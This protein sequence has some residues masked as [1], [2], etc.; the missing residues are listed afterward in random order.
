M[1]NIK[2]A[3]SIAVATLCSLS[4]LAGCIFAPSSSDSEK[5]SQSS[6]SP[7]KPVTSVLP[8]Y[9]A[10][11]DELSIS[12]AGWLAP[13]NFEEQQMQY[14]KESGL[15]TIFFMQGLT[16][17]SEKLDAGLKTLAEE[18]FKAYMSTASKVG[19]DFE[20]IANYKDYEAVLG[21]HLDEPDK[22]Q[23]DVIAG[24]VNTYNTIA[25]GKTMYTNLYPSFA[26]AIQSDFENYD[27]YLEYYCDNVLEK[28]TTGEKWLSADRYPLTYN[29]KGEKS[30]DVGWLAD[31]EAVARVA[32]KYENVQTN[33][34]IQTM[35]Y[36]GTKYPA[37]M[38]GSRDRD[39]TYEDVRLQE[40]SLLAFGYDRISLFCYA[41]P[42]VG[43]E[44]TEA[45]QAM[46]DRDGNPTSIYH[47]AKKANT[48]VK[49]FD[50]V[51]LQFDWQGIF[52][53]DGGKT[54]TDKNKTQNQSFSNLTNRMSLEVIDC[55]ESVTSTVDTLFGYFLDN[56]DN[57]GFMVVNYN[58]TSLNLTD[59]VTLQFNA[60]YQYTKAI[61]YIGGEKQIVDVTDNQIVLNLGVGEGV[62][63]IP[64]AA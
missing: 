59:K 3:I 18:G 46:I 38:S 55:L 26:T 48:E 29:S 33:F 11:E 41:T 42:P 49:A 7:Q 56:E 60:D 53:N 24:Y 57:A 52:T 64:Y 58:E 13:I 19:T 4:S 12:L 61:V 37:P 14:L 39:V 30:L 27:A 51:Y 43:V 22:A 17:P 34:F 31:V 16:S 21:M 1:K 23:M 36:G 10:K 32:R 35:P 6:G 54:T 2:K 8:N 28:L 15:D 63:V 45:Q 47:A 44:F 9:D 25:G 20:Y 40:Y 50:H 5:D 62:F